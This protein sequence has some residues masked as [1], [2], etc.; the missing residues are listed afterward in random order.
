LTASLMEQTTPCSAS[1]SRRWLAIETLSQKTASTSTLLSRFCFASAGLPS[2]SEGFEAAFRSTSS[3]LCLPC[4]VCLG[5]ALNKIMLLIIDHA[6]ELTVDQ[7]APPSSKPTGEGRR[8]IPARRLAH[9]SLA[10]D[11]TEP[12][13][14]TG[15]C[16]L[17]L[18]SDIT[19]K[20]YLYG[21]LGPSHCGGKC[22]CSWASGG[23]ERPVWER[24]SFKRDG[25]IFR[26]GKGCLLLR[27]ARQLAFHCRSDAWGHAR[28]G[29]PRRLGNFPALF[30]F[31]CRQGQRAPPSFL[32]LWRGQTSSNH[33]RQPP[34]S[35]Q[36]SVPVRW[37]SGSANFVRITPDFRWMEPR[38]GRGFRHHG[39]GGQGVKPEHQG[40]GRGQGA[41]LGDESQ[42]RGSKR[43]SWLEKSNVRGTGTENGH[44]AA[45]DGCFREWAR[46]ASG[47]RNLQDFELRN[48]CVSLMILKAMGW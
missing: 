34:G 4:R 39:F 9:S 44:G 24:I 7:S 43:A 28:T 5:R 3:R 13:P 46:R 21:W 12:H 2:F 18:F 41:G 32:F 1:F 35:L 6:D 17:F 45:L 33:R 22:G 25:L 36:K 42:N 47:Q 40:L 16:D 48:F 23:G 38:G 31:E 27:K 20:P 11:Q 30:V 37:A 14:Q 19:A 26:P 15:P 10:R 8:R 29:F